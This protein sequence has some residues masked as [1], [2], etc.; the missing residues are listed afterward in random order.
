MKH[1]HTNFE[2]PNERDKRKIQGLTERQA[3]D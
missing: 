2:Q 3:E 1:H